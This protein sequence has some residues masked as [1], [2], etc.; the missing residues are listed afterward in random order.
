MGKSNI[1]EGNTLRYDK[2]LINNVTYNVDNIN[3]IPAVITA[4]TACKQS[5]E[6]ILL[7]TKSHLSL[8]STLLSLK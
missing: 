5:D 2:L 3:T 8:T 1:V 6:L 7:Y 4:Q